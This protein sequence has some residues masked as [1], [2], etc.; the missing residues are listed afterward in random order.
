MI[1]IANSTTLAVNYLLI[2]VCEIIALIHLMVR[3]YNKNILNKF[4][5]VILHLIILITA[6]PV[7]DDSDY[8]SPLVI[9]IS[10]VLITVPLIYFISMTFYLHK[11][12][13]K[14]VVMHFKFKHGLPSNNNVI[15][16][17]KPIKEFDF[18]IDDSTRKN[19]TVCDM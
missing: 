5:G 7:F 12:I 13:L 6:L 11:D 4:D 15:S 14:E 2:A 17:E 8:D 3:P 10:F 19:A 9:T 1:I 18:V 16:N